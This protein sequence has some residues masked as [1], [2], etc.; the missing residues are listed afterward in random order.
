M[1]NYALA[2]RHFEKCNY[3]SDE[4]DGPVLSD[5]RCASLKSLLRETEQPRTHM[6]TFL[7]ASMNTHLN[8]CTYTH[9]AAQVQPVCAVCGNA[10]H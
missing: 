1:M 6:G 2:P 5:I 8:M 3:L 7:Y 9:G 4:A 10:P